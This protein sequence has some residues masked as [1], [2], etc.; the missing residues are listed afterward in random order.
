MYIVQCST[1][2]YSTV[3]YSAVQCSAV[4]C[5]AVQCSTLQCSTVQYSAV[6]CS[7]VQCSAVHCI[8][9][10]YYDSYLTMHNFT[11]VTVCKVACKNI[12]YKLI[13]HGELDE[14][15]IYMDRF[16]RIKNSL[17]RLG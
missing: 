1:V 16:D 9:V 11:N 7:A 2:Q 5:S 14:I 4:Q 6:Q 10:V 12:K 13:V 15:Y 17:F 3:Q 8:V